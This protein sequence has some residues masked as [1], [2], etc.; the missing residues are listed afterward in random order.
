[1]S[2]LL[3]RQFPLRH[4]WT[5]VVNRSQQDIDRNKAI[6]DVLSPPLLVMLPTADG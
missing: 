4:G 6:D 5:G 3:G 2:I 1:M